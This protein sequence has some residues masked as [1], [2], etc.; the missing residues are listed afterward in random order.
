[1]SA[2]L[3]SYN[4]FSTAT[5]RT[6]LFGRESTVASTPDHDVI[7]TLS[8]LLTNFPR[9]RAPLPVRPHQDGNCEFELF[10]G[11]AQL[12]VVADQLASDVLYPIS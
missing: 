6:S 3:R 11:P 9:R 5:G 10:S 8:T 2:P 12:N 1:M 7:M 4:L